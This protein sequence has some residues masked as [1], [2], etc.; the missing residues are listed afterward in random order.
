MCFGSIGLCVDD[1]CNLDKPWACFREYCCSPDLKGGTLTQI[2]YRYYDCFYDQGHPRRVGMQWAT[3]HVIT[4]I[5]VYPIAFVG[6]ILG[7]V[8]NIVGYPWLVFWS[9]RNATCVPREIYQ[10]VIDR[11][12]GIVV[13]FPESPHFNLELKKQMS[14]KERADVYRSIVL[15][16]RR[17]YITHFKQYRSMQYTV[18]SS[19]T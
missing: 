17:A 13:S 14:E 12:D 10:E 1:H 2:G 16:V 6:F 3:L 7:S 5:V 4:G 9:E 19:Q 8:I 15:H 18:I 11:C